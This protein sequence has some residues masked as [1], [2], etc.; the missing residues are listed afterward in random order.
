MLFG[1]S[2]HSTIDTQSEALT[3][4]LVVWLTALST[5]LRST[6]LGSEPVRFIIVLNQWCVSG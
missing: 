2:W 6:L 3:E 4:E 1:N 5:F